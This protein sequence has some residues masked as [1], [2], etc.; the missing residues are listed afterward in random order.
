MAGY[1]GEGI[2]VSFP[3]PW[4][5]PFLNIVLI[6]ETMKPRNCCGKCSSCHELVIL[7]A[8]IAAAAIVLGLGALFLL[9]V[10]LPSTL[11]RV[12]IYSC[13][14]LGKLQHDF[15]QTLKLKK[16]YLPFVINFKLQ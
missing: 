4:A 1:M 10:L 14:T 3:N 5:L 9:F 11:S 7:L 6:H 12:L 8:I 15:P 2:I 16:K 13:E